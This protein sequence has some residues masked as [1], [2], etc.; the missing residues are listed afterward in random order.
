MK[1]AHCQNNDLA[2]ESK[3]KKP[4]KG[5]QSCWECK[6]RKMRCAFASPSGAICVACERRG[7][8]C[9]SQEAA[10]QKQDSTPVAGGQPIGEK[11]NRI[12]ELLEQC[13]RMIARRGGA[14]DI[15]GGGQ[16]CLSPKRLARAC[17]GTALFPRYTSP[18]LLGGSLRIAQPSQLELERALVGVWPEKVDVDSIVKLKVHPFQ[19]VRAVNCA[20][21]FH[22]SHQDQTISV[23]PGKALQLP[24]EG[25]HPVIVARKLLTLALFLQCARP[26]TAKFDSIMTRAVEAA[27]YLV[28]SRDDLVG[29]LE[30]IECLLMEATFEN[31]AG[32]L[33]R[34]WLATRRA[35]A[36]AQMIGLEEKTMP[37]AASAECCTS[38]E[39]PLDPEHMWFRLI[40]TDRF[41]SLMSGLPQGTGADSFT[42]AET[43]QACSPVQRLQRIHCTASGRLLQRGKGRNSATD[44]WE[45]DRLLQNA[46]ECVPTQWWL[47]PQLDGGPDETFEEISR[48]MDQMTHYHLIVQLH[49]PWAMSGEN[50]VC[51]HSTLSAINAS[52]EVMVRY[53]AVQ[54]GSKGGEKRYCSSLDSLAFVSSV[55]LCWVHIKYSNQDPSGWGHQ[56]YGDRAIVEWFV[57]NLRRHRERNHVSA[58]LLATLERLLDIQ[59]DG[60]TYS[61]VLQPDAGGERVVGC[62][63]RVSD[64]NV[65][66][67]HIPCLGEVI[68]QRSDNSRWTLPEP[69]P[70]LPDMTLAGDE[71]SLDLMAFLQD[72][73]Y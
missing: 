18:D 50:D 16:R 20:R 32:N 55:C 34:A 43:M 69:F 40:Q 48:M 13:A 60:S 39:S 28:T 45:I 6:R 25:T 51:L 8:S 41:L 53:M 30:G 24:P 72:S 33:R 1:R 70:S 37:S 2:A 56:R 11:L 9:V 68:I 35:M 63:G 44:M 12:G 22:P 26:S 47:V 10:Q 49:L 64:D 52:R 38:D 21:D 31:N 66:H 61:T 42:D 46:S 19:V 15:D 36:T 17:D 71:S 59:L 5:T 57:E 67:I 4:R 62:G 65:L 73:T 14:E 29:S 3:T 58:Q 23:A 54:K 27:R 7:T